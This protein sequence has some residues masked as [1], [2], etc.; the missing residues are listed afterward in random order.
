MSNIEG[1]IIRFWWWSGSSSGSRDSLKDSFSIAV[2][3]NFQGVG[4][5]SI[6]YS[7]A[8]VSSVVSIYI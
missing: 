7:S 3:S 6:F 5:W 1:D 2:L 8:L 4:P